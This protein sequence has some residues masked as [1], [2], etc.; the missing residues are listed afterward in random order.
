MALSTFPRRAIAT[1][2]ACW[3]TA[4]PYCRNLEWKVALS[5]DTV[6]RVDRPRPSPA[7]RA[8]DIPGRTQGSWLARHPLLRCLAIYRQI[9]GLF[10]LCSGLFIITHIVGT[11]QQHLIGRAVHDLELGRAVVRLAD[12]SLQST[13]A[14]RW[15][16]LLIVVAFGRGLLQYTAGVLALIVGQ[17]LLSRLR[18]SILVQVQRLDLASAP[19]RAASPTRPRGGRGLR[20][21]Q[22]RPG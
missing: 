16:V 2:R 13:V 6:G 3:T 22:S 21:C 5:L 7:Y 18:V 11:A 9:P 19:H 8:P 20:Q 14:Y 4:E 1:I 12:G 10:A 15:V 17:E